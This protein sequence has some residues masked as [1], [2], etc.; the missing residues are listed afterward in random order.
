V[1]AWVVSGV[2]TNGV[3]VLLRPDV[4]MLAVNNLEYFDRPASR[5]RLA[6]ALERLRGRRVYSLCLTEDLAS[7]LDLLRRRRLV[8]GAS[9]RVIVPFF[10]ARTRLDMTLV[11]V[12]LPE[13][14]ETPRKGPGQPA[15]TE[16]TA[17]LDDDAF[18]AGISVAD[19]PAVLR[20]GARADIRVA[21]K[22]LSEFVWPARGRADYAFLIT[23]TNGW[24]DAGGSLVDNTDGKAGLPRDLWPGDEAEITLA[25]TAPADPGEYI[26]EI[27]LVQEGIAWFK[28]KGS[29]AWRARVK[30]E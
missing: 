20:A 2:K 18:L 22:N 7:S 26:L 27:D 3:E 25:V 24:F 23:V 10:S 17:P 6:G 11:E 30:V 21:V 1:D 8:P 19:A 29:Q 16:A 13:K 12:G 15:V 9:R 14:R 28:D 5:R 4:P